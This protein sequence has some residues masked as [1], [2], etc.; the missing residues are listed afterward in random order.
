[1]SR[2]KTVVFNQMS[3]E[4]IRSSV[5]SRKATIRLFNA[6]NNDTSNVSSSPVVGR[7][8]TFSRAMQKL[9]IET[10]SIVPSSISQEFSLL[11]RAPKST[12]N[13]RSTSRTRKIAFNPSSTDRE[14]SRLQTTTI[15]E[16]DRTQQNSS[17]NQSSTV[18]VGSQRRL[19]HGANILKVTDQRTTP[20]DRNA[21]VIEERKNIVAKRIVTP[22]ITDRVKVRDDGNRSHFIRN[23]IKGEEFGLKD[24]TDNSFKSAFSHLE[25]H[26]P[27]LANVTE[28][29]GS[30]TFLITSRRSPALESEGRGATPLSLLLNTSLSTTNDPNHRKGYLI[31]PLDGLSFGQ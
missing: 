17:L 1:M 30:K 12:Q 21:T 4:S 28:P 18:R 31:R 27:S 7:E 26:F 20:K 23:K 9:N 14:S 13:L 22:A 6:H 24:S 11:A 2:T 15:D 29:L 8:S 3:P 16:T 25:T 5:A 19:F 10:S